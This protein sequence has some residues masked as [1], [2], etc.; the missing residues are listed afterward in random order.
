M[1]Q[2]RPFAI[3][4]AVQWLIL[5]CSLL[6]TEPNYPTLFYRNLVTCEYLLPRGTDDQSRSFSASLS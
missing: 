6:M 2:A 3:L 4:G 5:T 1:K